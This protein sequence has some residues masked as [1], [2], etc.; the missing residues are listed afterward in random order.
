MGS[1]PPVENNHQINLLVYF[2][3]SPTRSIVMNR[4]KVSSHH[5]RSKAWWERWVSN[6]EKAQNKGGDFSGLRDAY[7]R[8]SR[9]YELTLSNL[10]ERAMSSCWLVSLT[11]TINFYLRAREKIRTDGSA[12][13]AN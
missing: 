9:G 10:E 7:V 8:G 5:F 13:V 3:S 12:M 1:A 11:T 4:L 2:R 6:L